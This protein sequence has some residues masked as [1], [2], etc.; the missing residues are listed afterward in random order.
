M[1]HTYT[2][3]QQAPLPPPRLPSSHRLPYRCNSS[4]K[5]PSPAGAPGR[6]IVGLVSGGRPVQS[7]TSRHI[8]PRYARG[9][10][11]GH[12]LA[13]VPSQRGLGASDNGVRWNMVS[14]VIMVRNMMFGAT[15]C[16]MQHDVR[17]S[18][19]VSDVT[20]CST[21]HA[22]VSRSVVFVYFGRQRR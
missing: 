11:A 5:K 12:L 8:L 15:W 21:W 18:M 16:S 14:D 19:V 1:Q 17:R 6:A 2:V 22:R 10:V 20:R 9:I 3:K 7:K 13:Q 4:V